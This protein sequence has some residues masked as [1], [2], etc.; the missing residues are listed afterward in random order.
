MWNYNYFIIN[1]EARL[2]KPNLIPINILAILPTL[3]LKHLVVFFEYWIIYVAKSMKL[4]QIMQLIL[5]LLFW[6]FTRQNKI[7]S[8]LNTYTVQSSNNSKDT[9]K[10]P[11]VSNNKFWHVFFLNIKQKR[12]LM[13]EF[14]VCLSLSTS[15]STS[16]SPCISS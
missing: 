8:T 10:V 2:W 12:E 4:M 6:L 9:L 16:L 11:F 13:C 3:N 1:K 14:K 5:K 15:M 7:G